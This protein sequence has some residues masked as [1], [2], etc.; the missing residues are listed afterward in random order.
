VTKKH[1]AVTISAPLAI[2]TQALS[3]VND[4]AAT[5]TEFDTGAL[6]NSDT[7]VPTSKAVTTAIA[8]R[9]RKNFIINGLGELYQRNAAHTL[10]KDVY[11][12]ATDRFYGMATG[13]LVSAGTLTQATTASCGR[14][15]YAH[16]FAGVTLTGTGI[17]RYRYRMEAKDAIQFKNQTASFSSRVYQDTGGAIDFTVYIRKADA[18][19]NF[20]AV[21]AISNSGAISIPNSTDTVLK[22]E[23][24]SMGDCSNGI[25]IEIYI[26]AGAI[27]TKNFYLTEVQFELGAAATAFEYRPYQE[28]VVLAWRYYQIYDTPGDAYG[29]FTLTF[30]YDAST[31]IGIM[32]LR[33]AM[34]AIPT[35]VSVGAFRAVG[36]V[37]KNGLTPTVGAE[38]TVSTTRVGVLTS[39]LSAG[40]C[41]WLSADNDVTCAWTFESEL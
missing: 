32:V 22:Y 31:L 30:A 18:A 25:E 13:T 29:V 37:I 14:T 1:V 16:K 41:Y 24:I 34:R 40:H 39:G 7:V 5:V 33:A 15:G 4:A 17:L 10:V 6:A 11:G 8:T 27:T 26:A 9:P 3:V 36:G 20:A 12:I 21:T 38:S 35:A 2:S 23:N 28:E 19:D